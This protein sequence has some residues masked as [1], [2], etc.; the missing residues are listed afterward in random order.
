[1]R[2]LAEAE[3]RSRQLAHEEAARR[4]L[5]EAEKTSRR[6][7]ERVASRALVRACL[8]PQHKACIRHLGSVD[9]EVVLLATLFAGHSCMCIATY[10]VLWAWFF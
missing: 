3:E 9:Y 8:G 4:Q 10:P 6:K 7:A 2:Q 5:A 1:M